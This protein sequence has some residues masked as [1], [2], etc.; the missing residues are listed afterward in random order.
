MKNEDREDEEEEKE[1]FEE[2]I[3]RKTKI[4]M[5]ERG[6]ARELACKDPLFAESF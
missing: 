2:E 4:V 1:D 5:G 6:G 3:R